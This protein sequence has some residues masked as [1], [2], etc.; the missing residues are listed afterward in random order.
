MKTSLFVIVVVVLLALGMWYEASIWK[1]CRQD[2]SWFY[3]TRV[4]SK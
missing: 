1:E 3:C 2:H 4:L